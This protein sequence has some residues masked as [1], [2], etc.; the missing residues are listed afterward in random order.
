MPCPT[1]PGCACSASRR[2]RTIAGSFRTALAGVSGLL[3]AAPGAKG[4]SSGASA[5]VAPLAFDGSYSGAFNVHNTGGSG[6]FVATM[7]VRI[8]NGSGAGTISISGGSVIW[9]PGSFSIQI[10]P[11]GAV[12]G[13]GE[14]TGAGW[15]VQKL[16]ITGQA[17][18]GQLKLDLSGLDRPTGATL[19]RVSP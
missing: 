19:A 1:A 10:G 17:A 9:P 16:N 18:G 5:S 14:M 12:S 7:K 11:T 2:A 13:R 15:I 4:D 3:K 6:S 8:A